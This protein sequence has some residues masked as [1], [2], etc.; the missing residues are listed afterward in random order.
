[1]VK[2]E[3]I[4]IVA[5][6]GVFVIFSG[7][8]EKTTDVQSNYVK[9]TNVQSTD[10]QPT[11]LKT[12]AQYTISVTEIKTLQDCINSGP[13]KPCTLINL[14]VKNNNLKSLDFKIVTEEVISKS[15]KLLED[16]YDRQVGLSNLCVRQAGMEFKL[17]AN[18]NQ[19]VALC[20]PVVHI[21]DAPSLNIGALINGER[22]DY[23]FDLIKYGLTD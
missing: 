11:A 21:S 10:V 7:C 17:N 14:D 6:I 5:V 3:K 12:E 13:I 20:Y 4:V 22:K 19:N 8:A 18:T 23:K 2:I 1:M 16:R 9:P 15:G